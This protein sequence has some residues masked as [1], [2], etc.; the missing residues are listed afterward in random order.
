MAIKGFMANKQLKSH[1]RSYESMSLDAYS[2]ERDLK[3]KLL[4]ELDPVCHWENCFTSS[5]HYP[6]RRRK[7]SYYDQG[8][9]GRF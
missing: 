1:F 9:K 5:R 7:K 6:N 4:F 2:D 3:F 8:L